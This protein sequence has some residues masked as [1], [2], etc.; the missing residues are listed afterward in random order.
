MTLLNSNF[1]LHE[2]FKLYV[3]FKLCVYFKLREYFKL[4]VYFI[5]TFDAVNSN[6]NDANKT[7]HEIITKQIN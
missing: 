6:Y 1:K 4:H 7:E 5:S 2:Y 3:Y